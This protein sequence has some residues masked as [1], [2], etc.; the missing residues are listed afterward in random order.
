[1]EKANIEE[2]MLKNGRYN[3]NE[4]W[5]KKHGCAEREK[6]NVDDTG[7]EQEYIV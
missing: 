6:V 7:L 2:P 3:Q 5:D 4:A 1:M